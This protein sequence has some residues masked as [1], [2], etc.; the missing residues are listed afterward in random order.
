MNQ[1][2]PK[3]KEPPKAE[4]KDSACSFFSAMLRGADPKRSLIA[5]TITVATKHSRKTVEA[6]YDG[7]A[8]P[9]PRE[10]PIIACALDASPA[11]VAA[12]WMM[13]VVPELTTGL[14]AAVQGERFEKLARWVEDGR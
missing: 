1:S 5:D 3:D 4:V 10:L 2:K 6:W 14:F 8:M 13:T 11:H 9:E 12:L 7:T